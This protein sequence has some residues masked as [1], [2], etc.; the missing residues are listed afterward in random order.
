MHD[1]QALAARIP[2]ESF[3]FEHHWLE[4]DGHRIHYVDD[5][6]GPV[7][8]LVNVGMW[9]FVFRDLMLRLRD[10]FRV[11]ALDFPGLGL[12][13]ALDGRF[14][15]VASNS[16]LLEH[17]V[18]ELDLRDV[19]LLVHD[20]GGP[21]G[22]GWAARRPERVRALIVANTFAFPLREYPL[23]RGM[24][25][26]VTSRPFDA[27]NE[28]TNLFARFTSSGAGVGRHLDR[29]DRDAFLVPWARRSTR[30]ASI[31]A[32]RSVRGIES[33]Q[34]DVEEAMT[35]TLRERPV[36]TVFGSRNDPFGWQER[37]DA[38]MPLSR[39]LRVQGGNHFPFADAP[40]EVAEAI[41]SWWHELVESDGQAGNRATA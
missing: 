38:M 21:V 24:L 14:P 9:S 41:D 35:T 2:P 5:G 22:L 20:V 16:M 30:R 6:S 32:L 7:L 17:F 13:S 23:I 1:S 33:W 3:P 18:D 31:A 28:R 29:Q 8:L 11:V 4:A 27:L 15:D 19:T 25:R 40:A 26:L 34:A 37:I 10:R 36:L 12:S 39:H